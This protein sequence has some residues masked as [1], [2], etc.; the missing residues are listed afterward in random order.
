MRRGLLA[1]VLFFVFAPAAAAAPP[2][3]ARL[4]NALAVPGSHPAASGAVA[5]DLLTGQTLFARNPDVPLLP[6]SNEKLTVTYAALVEL[7][8]AYRFRT[9]LLGRGYQDGATWHGDLYLKGFG[10]PTLDSLDLRRLG[11]QLKGAG[12]RRVDGR[13][14]G[15]ESWFDAQRTAPGWKSSF[16]LFEC[17]ALSALVVDHGVYEHHLARLPAVAAAGRFRRL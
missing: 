6:A 1:I 5:V 10:D 11:A 7:G 8:P 17:P 4:A 16:F 2:L 3:T 12:I 15:D 9:Q 14:L 13:I